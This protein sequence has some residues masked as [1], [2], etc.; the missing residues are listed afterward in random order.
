MI[1]TK[2]VLASFFL[3]IVSCCPL[4]AQQSKDYGWPAITS[5]TKPWT[6]W[7]WMGSAVNRPDLSILLTDYQKAGLGGVEITPIYG[8]RGYES[9]FIDYLSPKWMDMLSHTL[10]EAQRLNMGVDV[11]Q[12][13]GWPF[14]GPWVKP[15]DASKYI[16]YLAYALNTGQ[17]ISEPIL[18]IQKPLVT[19]VAKPVD[20]KQLKDPI[21]ANSNLQELSVEQVRFEKELPLKTVMAYSDQGEVLDLTSKIDAQKRLNWV[22]PQGKWM[23]YALFQGWHGKLVERAGPGGEGDVIDHFSAKATTNYLKHF[24]K[25]FS[26]KD[27]GGVRAFFNDSYEVDDAIGQGDWT[28]EVLDEFKKRRGYDL[29]N[30]LPALFGKDTRDISKRVRSDYRETISELILENFNMTWHKWAKAKGKIIRNQAHGAPGNLLDLYAVSDIPETEGNDLLNIKMASSAAHVT[31]K[32]LISSE[33]ATWENEHFLSNLSA[34]KKAVDRFFLG[35]VNHI[36]YHGTN[37]S[38]KQEVWPGWQFYAASELNP[39]NSLWDHFSTLNNYVTRVQSFLQ[40][41]RAAHDVLV[42]YPVYDAFSETGDDLLLNFHDVKREFAGLSFARDSEFLLKK[43]YGFDFISDRQLIDLAV[44]GV[45]PKT[46]A[47]RYKTLVFLEPKFMPVSTLRQVLQ[48]AKEGM[49]V[50]FSKHLPTDVPGL[51]QLEP[52][53][54][55]FKLLLDALNFS[56]ASPGIR[57]AKI[58]QGQIIVGEDI[59]LLL[60]QAGA[61]R[62]EMIDQGLQSVRRT[63]KEGSIYFITNGST[64]RLSDW[65]PLSVDFV[66]AAVFNP[67]TNAQGKAKVS[68]NPS[69][70]KSVYLQLNP[71]ESCIVQTFNRPVSG[72]GYPYFEL[73]G[74]PK[75]LTGNWTVDF[76]K[77]GPVLPEKVTLKTFKSWTDFG[78]D[79][80]KN[81]SG[82]A[83][84]HTSFPIPEGSFSDWLLDLGTVKE[85]A[86]VILNGKE[87]A[88][89]I[90][91]V[92]QV[93]IPAGDLKQHNTLE[94]RVSNLMANRIADLDRRKVDWKKFYNINFISLFK[95]NRDSNGRFDFSALQPVTSG[96]LGE[97]TLSPLKQINTN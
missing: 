96:L 36:F 1:D 72:I 17:K 32:R 7:W 29:R 41:G 23:V 92:F 87:V 39:E 61:K 21:S 89:L 3:M 67:M 22:A 54:K 86:K 37:Y 64:S 24:D 34:I 65:V 14:G 62:E 49:T 47:E 85:S 52:R 88:T 59:S 75:K 80:F 26:G 2:N 69:G 97:V 13:S 90:G 10:K 57:T 45:L 43:G 28:P 74:K 73:A 60:G 51:G 95:E 50:V 76:I 81:F 70:R 66:S 25:V 15:E 93:S 78:G 18:Y 83:G 20:I 44:S 77:G 68:T 4:Y 31:G 27:I 84:Y 71:G 8:V 63:H 58:G 56:I 94:I 6:R 91:P 46:A 9:Q 53:R 40:S 38:P 11:A 55:E 35:G 5:E 48:L 33:S 42:Y 16:T 82:T 12:A 19:G 30:Y 79:E